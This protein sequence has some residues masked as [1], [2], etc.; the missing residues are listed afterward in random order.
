M[1]VR[2]FVG[3]WTITQFSLPRQWNRNLCTWTM[4]CTPGRV[5]CAAHIDYRS[6]THPSIAGR[7]LPSSQGMGVPTVSPQ[8][9]TLPLPTHLLPLVPSLSPEPY[10][11]PITPFHPYA[12]PQVT[13]NAGGLDPTPAEGFCLP[14]VHRPPSYEECELIPSHFLHLSRVLTANDIVWDQY[15][16]QHQP[17]RPD[18]LCIGVPSF[19]QFTVSE[20]RAI[21]HTIYLQYHPGCR[22]IRSPHSRPRRLLVRPPTDQAVCEGGTKA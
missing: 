17:S 21:D 8:S 1:R 16:H 15:N 18:P 7:S 6:T 9:A 20:P 4:G 2:M 19:G 14:D 22:L 5:S 10:I 13:T 11:V 3:N 12:Q